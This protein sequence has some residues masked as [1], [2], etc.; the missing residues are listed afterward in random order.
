MI[1]ATLKDGKA[2]ICC[3]PSKTKNGV[4]LVRVEPEGPFLVVSHF[5]PAY[6]FR[7]QC[8]H[9]EEAVQCYRNWRYW[10]PKREVIERR[11]RIILQP[12]WEQIPVPASMEEVIEA[13]MGVESRAS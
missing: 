13:A 5:C 8:S 3:I 11:Q 10:E 2:L 12:H 9:V 7:N 4:Y 6:R 1:T